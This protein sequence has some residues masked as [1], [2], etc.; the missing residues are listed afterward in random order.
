MPKLVGVKIGKSDHDAPVLDHLIA[1]A[2]KPAHLAEPQPRI[3]R[4]RMSGEDGNGPL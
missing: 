3:D 2:R 1:T 4:A